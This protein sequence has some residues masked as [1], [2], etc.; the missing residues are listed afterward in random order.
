M[1]RD[2][3]PFRGTYCTQLDAPEWQALSMK[4]A[5][6]WWGLKYGVDNNAAGLY[7]VYR[8]ALA[9]RSRVPL[10]DVQAALRELEEHDWIRMEGRWVWLRNH[11]QYDPGFSADN[12]NQMKGLI[13]CINGLPKIKLVA[14]FVT[15]YK[16]LG[17]IPFDYEWH[18]DETAYEGPSN[19]LRMAFEGASDGLASPPP[20]NNVI[21]TNTKPNKRAK[22]PDTPEARAIIEAYNRIIGGRIQ[23]TNGNLTAARRALDHGHTVEDV[24]VVFEAVKAKRGEAATWCANNNHK[25]EYMTRPPY[26]HPKTGA[27]TLGPIEKIQNDLGVEKPQIAAVESPSERRRRLEGEMRARKQ[28]AS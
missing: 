13:R 17:I 16:E 20:N 19:G 2:R 18:L 23:P 3:G 14:D 8:D 12:Q 4:A 26:R 21:E 6:L 9:E 22:N 27:L 5:A 1:G 7:P 10:D 28:E 15:Y 11:L 24:T 25:F